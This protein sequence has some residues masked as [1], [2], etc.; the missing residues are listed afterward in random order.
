MISLNCHKKSL[1]DYS[2]I[3]SEKFSGLSQ[4]TTTSEA[5]A[6][7]L[8][9]SKDSTPKTLSHQLSKSFKASRDLLLSSS[10][11]ESTENSLTKALLKI[12][13]TEYRIGDERLDQ[14]KLIIT[15]FN[16]K[17]KKILNVD[18]ANASKLRKQVETS[19]LAFDT[20]R[21]E[22]K[23]AQKGDE[24]AEI[25]ENL[26]KKLEASEDDLVNATEL[27]VESMKD[28]IK[29]LEAVSLVKVFAKIQLNYHKAAVTELSQLVDELDTLPVD[30][31]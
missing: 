27:A 12:S 24:N 28:L 8:A 25:P 4:A 9:T 30:D 17:V 21:A 5:E 13:E 23:V 3:I 1:T 6:V 26:S 19:R 2:K 31:E 18:F 29:P 10:E 7:L 14:D 16:A 15:E 22:I 20:V 11:E